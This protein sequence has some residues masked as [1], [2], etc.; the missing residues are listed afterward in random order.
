MIVSFVLFGCFLLGFFIDVI[1]PSSDVFWLLEV[2]F[3]KSQCM[4]TLLMAVWP[5][6]DD[7]FEKNLV[8]VKLTPP[9]DDTYDFV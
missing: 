2:F 9:S 4:L 6:E 8:F 5:L 1:R 3:K 7:T